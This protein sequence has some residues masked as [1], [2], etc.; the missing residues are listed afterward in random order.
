[1]PVRSI[2]LFIFGGVSQLGQEPK[3]P[4]VEFRMALAGP[5]TSLLIGGIF[6]GIWFATRAS[7]DAIVGLAFWLA[8]INTALA[9]FNLIPGFPLDGGRVLRS[10]LWWR[11]KDLRKATQTAS[12]IGRSIGY[13]F[14]L[15]GA[16]L[17]FW[18]YW[19]NGLWI[20]FIGWFIGNAAKGSYQ[21]VALQD[22]LQGH[23]VKEIM[24][25][26]CTEISPKITVEQLVNDHILLSGRRCMTVTDDGRVLG[27]VTTHN[28]KQ[29]SRDQW[30]IVKV[31]EIVI[32]LDDLRWVKPDED[33]TN[34][35]QILTD[36]DINQLPVLENGK[37]VGIL[38]RDNL[39]DF[40]RTKVELGI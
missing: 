36:A 15:G 3:Q 38:A 10:I 19:I 32:P 8:W 39:L 17:F 18:G 7:G 20:A 11:N 2:T 14:M 35:F 40:L 31:K 34:V 6:W 12:N 4:A 37:L 26:D 33:L 25:S 30:P 22:M 16:L 5:L 13:L 28:V 29:V 27:L 24:T 21:Q 1:M 9:A 23:T